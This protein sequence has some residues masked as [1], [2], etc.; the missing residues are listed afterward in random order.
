MAAGLGAGRPLMVDIGPNLMHVIDTGLKVMG[1]V[2][3]LIFFA[4]LVSQQ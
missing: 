3:V 1:V 2:V 4:F